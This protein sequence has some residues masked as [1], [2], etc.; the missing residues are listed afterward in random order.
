MGRSRIKLSDIKNENILNQ[1]KTQIGSVCQNLTIQETK[2]NK[3]NAEKSEYDGG[4]YDSKKEALFARELD[5]LKKVQDDSKRVLKYE[6][7][8]RFDILIN[9]VLCFYYL[10]D[11]KV[12]Y[13]DGTIKYYDVK[14]YKKG[15]AYS[16]FRL[17]KKCV[18]AYYGIV[19]IEI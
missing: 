18:E 9:G 4:E 12:W 8:V 11:F 6:R 3:Y 5:V 10:L 14:G 2:K 13:A 15:C 16:L 19:I 17:K 1:I 7:Q